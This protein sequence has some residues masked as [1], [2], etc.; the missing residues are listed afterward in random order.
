MAS[1]LS[2][3]CTW[4]GISGRTY[5]FTIYDPDTS[6]NDVPGNYIFAH[7]TSA[8]R[9]KADYIGETESFKERFSNHEKWPCATRHGAT[10]V[11]AH[12]NQNGETARRAEETDLIRNY[13]PPCNEQY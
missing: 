11:H 5:Q 1:T 7:E 13:N 10:H 4:A 2:Q 12:V 3:T 9:W 6:W 8:G